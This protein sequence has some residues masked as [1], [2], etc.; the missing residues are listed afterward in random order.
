MRAVE[1][2][3]P[4]A[5]VMENV[6]P[7]LKSQEFVEIRKIAESMGYSVIGAVLNAADYGVPQTR[8][9]AIVLGLK[10]AIATMPDPTHI[11]RRRKDMFSAA[12]TATT[13]AECCIVLAAHC[14]ML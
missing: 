12:L 4:T 6:P 1:E 7:L 10:G 8:K 2:S 11:E 13:N 5:F 9:R 3:K 14:C